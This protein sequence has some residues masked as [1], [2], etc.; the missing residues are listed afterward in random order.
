MQPSPAEDVEVPVSTPAE[1]KSFILL[2]GYQFIAGTN[3]WTV[4][5]DYDHSISNSMRPPPNPQLHEEQYE[6]KDDADKVECQVESVEDVLEGDDPESIGPSD[7]SSQNNDRSVEDD[8]QPSVQTS[9]KRRIQ[10]SQLDDMISSPEETPT[11]PLP[12][13]QNLVDRRTELAKIDGRIPDD[14]DYVGID[15]HLQGKS[16]NAKDTTMDAEISGGVNPALSEIK[17]NITH[18]NL[19]LVELTSRGGPDDIGDQQSADQFDKL[20]T[21]VHDDE[22]HSSETESGSDEPV[23]ISA[24]RTANADRE[25]L[26]EISVN[27]AEQRMSFVQKSKP[28]RKS[29]GDPV[30]EEFQR[31]TKRQRLSSPGVTTSKNHPVSRDQSLHKE[32]KHK[33]GSTKKDSASF[34]AAGEDRETIPE[35]RPRPDAVG[36]ILFTEGGTMNSASSDSDTVSVKSS[37]TTTKSSVRKRSA[38]IGQHMNLPLKPKLVLSSTMKD[39]DLYIRIVKSLKGV[40]IDDTT[41]ADVLCVANGELKKTLKFI[42][43]VIHGKFITSE[44]WLRECERRC[45]FVDPTDYLPEDY[46]PENWQTTLADALARGRSGVTQRLLK[47]WTVFTTTQ[48]SAE[49]GS[50]RAKELKAIAEA[51]GARFRTRPPSKAVSDGIS[52]ILG[53]KDDPYVNQ[54]ADLGHNLYSREALLMAALRGNLDMDSDEFRIQPRIKEED[55]D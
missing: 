28:K 43:A 3:R 13:V 35:E 32:S 1:T 21:A 5:F 6:Q 50:E 2:D 44:T 14:T 55:S 24:L 42:L 33:H 34:P 17:T 51:L 18:V 37:S 22:I 46:V 27:A 31:I 39:R 20:A 40:L 38:R 53:S 29:E 15:D 19:S 41:K 30:G 9:V 4:E 52:L 45:T 36:N 48:L 54:I 26:H 11:Q 7:N 12:R 47:S 25:V 16:A 8:Q 49:L 10:L 23:E